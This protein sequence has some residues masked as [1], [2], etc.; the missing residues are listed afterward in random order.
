MLVSRVYYV[1]GVGLLYEYCMSIVRV[2]CVLCECCVGIVLIRCVYCV[3]G[4]CVL[5]A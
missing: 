5:C 2:L 4:A 1:F 3:G